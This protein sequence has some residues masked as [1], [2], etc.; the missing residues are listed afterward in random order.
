MDLGSARVRCLRA[1]VSGGLIEYFIFQTGQIAL[2]PIPNGGTF[3]AFMFLGGSVLVG[4]LTRSAARQRQK[5]ATANLNQ[6]L[7]LAQA[8]AAFATEKAVATELALENEVRSQMAL[9]GANVGLW[10]W[11]I[12]SQKSK[13]SHGYYRL[14]GLDP[15]QNPREAAT[16]ELWRRCIHPDDIERVESAI[17]RAIAERSSFLEEYRIVL[18]G[19]ITRWIACQGT[20]ITNPAGEVVRISGFG[21]DVTRRKLADPGPAPERKNDHRRPP[22]RHYRTRSTIPSTVP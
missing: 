20:A 17:R 10:E 2:S 9:D 5:A 18:R 14:H 1:V 7:L 3:R 12:A 11:D 22:H 6:R 13:W 8:E 15:D 21:G 4:V 16:Y 19:G